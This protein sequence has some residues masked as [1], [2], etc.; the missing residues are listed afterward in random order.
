MLSSLHSKKGRAAEGFFLC[1]GMKLCR[2]AVGRCDVRFAVIKEGRDGEELRDM[3]KASGGDIIVLSDSAF[4]KISSDETPDGIAFAVKIPENDGAVTESEAVFA[5]ECVRD[6]GNVG[7]IIRTAAALGVDRLILADCADL[8]NPKTVRASMGALFKMNFTVCGDLAE[9]IPELKKQGRRVISAAL[10]GSSVTLGNTD[11]KANDCLI[12]GNE[13]HGISE[14]TVNA[15][16][17]TVIIPMTD[18]TESLNAATA[19]AVLLWELGKTLK[20]V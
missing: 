16:D 10:T 9:V 6:P 7:T 3:A 2:E 1:E 20:L 19:S 5:L 8:Y 15:S 18:K 4:D 12:V 14:S 13:G 11:L 17:E